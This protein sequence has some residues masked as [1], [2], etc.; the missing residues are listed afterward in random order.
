VAQEQ[1]DLLKLAASRAT[2]LRASPASVM[3]RDARNADSPENT[4][5]V[6]PDNASRMEIN[7]IIHRDL[8]AKGVISEEEHRQTVLT[9]RQDLTGADR[10]WAAQYAPGEVIR[11]TIPVHGQPLLGDCLNLTG[12]ANWRHAR[13]PK[14]RKLTML[15]CRLP[16]QLT[17]RQQIASWCFRYLESG[18][19]SRECGELVLT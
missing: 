14:T 12:P 6:S 16:L 13:L 9:P 5:V 3:R 17:A 2:Q 11:Y 18:A 8:Q 19:G 4:L 7:R 1:L 10:Q 15:W